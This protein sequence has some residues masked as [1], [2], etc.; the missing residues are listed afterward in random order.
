MPNQRSRT[1]LKYIAKSGLSI[2]TITYIVRVG[3]VDQQV[4]TSTI[5]DTKVIVIFNVTKNPLLI[6]L[7]TLLWILHKL[8]DHT[9]NKGNVR[10]TMS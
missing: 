2:I 1:K 5:Y 9:N 4:W 7:V 6:L 8:R 3:E 10:L